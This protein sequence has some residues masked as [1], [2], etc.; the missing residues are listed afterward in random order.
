MLFE[1]QVEVCT[2]KGRSRMLRK[3]GTTS[4]DL[5][6][7]ST[8]LQ[9]C[10]CVRVAMEKTAPYWET[11]YIILDEGRLKVVVVDEESLQDE[12]PPGE[13][14]GRAGWLAYLLRRRR[15]ENSFFPDK[16]K[17]EIRDA[18]E[19]RAFLTTYARWQTD[20]IRGIVGMDY[21]N[22]SG[23]IGE[24]KVTRTIT[25][26]NHLLRDDMLEFPSEYSISRGIDERVHNLHPTRQ[27]F[28]EDLNSVLREYQS[29]LI[30][31]MLEMLDYYNLEIRQMDDLIDSFM[32]GEEIPEQ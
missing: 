25:M 24:R 11:L 23:K 20:N 4:R 27:Q 17:E 28:L 9:S 30:G 26:L 32:N 13:N 19:N 3:F 31:I 29:K 15:I 16:K 1:D 5:F 7:L 10:R 21:F 14:Q 2:L 12:D 6:Y 22:V 18:A 8:W